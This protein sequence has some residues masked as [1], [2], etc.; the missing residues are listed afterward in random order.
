M[1]RPAA[2]EIGRDGES[3][4][5][6]GPDTEAAGGPDTDPAGG[7]DTEP[8]GGPDAW[9]IALKSASQE[10]AASAAAAAS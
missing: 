10:A 7:P 9:A 8:A 2:G 6:G 4:R 3:G 5:P 1:A